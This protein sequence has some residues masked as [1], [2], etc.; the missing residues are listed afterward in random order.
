MLSGPCFR[1][2]KVFNF[3]NAGRKMIRAKKEN[4]N[5]PMVPTARENQKALSSPPVRKGTNPRTVDITVKKIGT[6]F[7]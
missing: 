4:I 1:R 7:P 3:I 2:D 5:P 6:I